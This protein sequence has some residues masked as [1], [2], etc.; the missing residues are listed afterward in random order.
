[1]RITEPP[2]M[3][4]DIVAQNNHMITKGS[5]YL[6]KLFSGRRDGYMGRYTCRIS[7]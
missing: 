5:T 6:R 3:P 1:M 4:N 7:C 2:N